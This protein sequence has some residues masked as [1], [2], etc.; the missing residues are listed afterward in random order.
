[1]TDEVQKIKEWLKTRKLCTMDEHM[2]FYCKEAESDYNLLCS[3]EKILDSMQE[4]PVSVWHDKDEEP[5]E[6]RQVLANLFGFC[7]VDFYHK[8]D[9]CFYTFGSIHKYYL[10]EVDKWAYIDDLI[11]VS[12]AKEEPVSEDLKEEIVQ[13]F[14]KHPVKNFT[15]WSVLKNIAL[16]FAE[17]GKN[18]FEDKSEMVSEDL[19]KDTKFHVGDRIRRIIRREFDRDM[20]VARVYK[21]Y[22]LCSNIGKFSST[23]IPFAEENDYELIIPKDV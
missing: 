8:E 7:Y 14:T 2:K 13:Y 23:M 22:Y 4:E 6:D 5:D 20:E 11:S 1:M 10:C 9:K 18:H 19:N 21:D 12:V 3:I 15:D 17:W 16:H